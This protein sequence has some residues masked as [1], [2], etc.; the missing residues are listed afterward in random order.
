MRSENMH[1]TNKEAQRLSIVH[2]LLCKCS[3]VAVWTV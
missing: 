3:Q 2:T 1:K